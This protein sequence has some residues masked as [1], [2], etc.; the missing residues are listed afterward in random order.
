MVAAGRG[1]PGSQVFL[2]RDGKLEAEAETDAAGNWVL[3]LD[4]PLPPG[5]Y[6]LSLEALLPSGERYRSGELVIASVP[7][8]KAEDDDQQTAKSGAAPK[9]EEAVA[10]AVPEQGGGA[11]VLQGSQEQESEGIRTLGLSI[12][13]VDYDAAGFIRV[14]GRGLPD[15]TIL[16]YLDNQ[17][18]GQTRVAEDERW[19]IAPEDAVEEGLYQLRVDQVNGAGEVI[20]RLE[21]VFARTVFI[22]DLPRDRMVVVQPGNSLWRLARRIYGEG[23]L[24]SVIY[25]A[26]QDQIRDPDLIYPGQIFI[27]PPQN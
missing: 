23:I 18:I 10:I 11:R 6:E 7:G 24:Y 2:L 9:E 4:Q 25:E 3:I 1:P 14:A 21:T 17:A 19:L 26:N 13:S 12:L 16:A 15:A 8:A 5:D 22:A 27:A 20:A